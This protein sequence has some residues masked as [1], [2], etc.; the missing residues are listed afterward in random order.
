MGLQD[1]LQNPEGRIRELSKNMDKET[2]TQ[3]KLVYLPSHPQNISSISEGP[4]WIQLFVVS[5]SLVA[6]P[7]ALVQEM[8]LMR[9]DG[10]VK[11]FVSLPT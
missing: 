8:T 7:E 2:A 6:S 3:T 11:Q 10:L 9:K 1:R 4:C 5:A